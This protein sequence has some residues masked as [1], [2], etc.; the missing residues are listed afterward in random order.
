MVVFLFI[1]IMFYIYII[2]SQQTG[3]FYIGQTNNLTDRILRHQSNRNR[4]T[5]GKGPWE[6][7][8]SQSFATRK[9]A[10]AMEKL[11]SWKNP[12]FLIRWIEEQGT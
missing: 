5:K 7:L 8:F 6:L 9:E 12:E 11:K 3:Q 2:K 4:W 10:M 1:N